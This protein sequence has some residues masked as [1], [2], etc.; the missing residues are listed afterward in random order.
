VFW[1]ILPVS[2]HRPRECNTHKRDYAE[3]AR[4]AFA[5]NLFLIHALGDVFSPT[6]IGLVSDATNLHLALV[7]TMPVAMLLSGIFYLMG[8]RYLAPDT[9]RV[10]ERIRTRE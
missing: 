6:L 9:E 1:R 8:M 2:Q 3:D 7:V 10:V 5:I 4:Y